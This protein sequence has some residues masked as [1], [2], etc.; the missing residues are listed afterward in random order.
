MRNTGLK[1]VVCRSSKV[2]Y[3]K[4]SYLTG[5]I[6][7]GKL[8][9]FHTGTFTYEMIGSLVFFLKIINKG[10]FQETY[11]RLNQMELI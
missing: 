11:D 8:T 10:M 7:Q 9:S 6:F 3:P 5:D 2:Y 4:V 1:S